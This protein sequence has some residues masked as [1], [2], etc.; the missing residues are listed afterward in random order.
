MAWYVCRWYANPGE[1]ARG[2]EHILAL[3]AKSRAEAFAR[4][5]QV[6]GVPKRAILEELA[7]ASAEDQEAIEGHLHNHWVRTGADT[8]NFWF[9]QI[10]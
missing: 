7:E 5:P 4:F 10:T 8:R 6:S 9:Y 2:K 1:Q 3:K